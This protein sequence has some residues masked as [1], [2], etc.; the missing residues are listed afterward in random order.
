MFWKC[1]SHESEGPTRR[2]SW[3]SL[4]SLPSW[5]PLAHFFSF[6]SDDEQKGRPTAGPVRS[7]TAGETPD[8]LFRRSKRSFR[9]APY[10]TTDRP[11][12]S[13]RCN[14]KKTS[15][16]VLRPVRYDEPFPRRRSNLQ[17]TMSPIESEECRLNADESGKKRI[18]RT[19]RSKS[20]H[21]LPA[22]SPPKSV[23]FRRPLI[24]LQ[25]VAVITLEDE[26]EELK[27]NH[28]CAL[29]VQLLGV[30][31]SKDFVPRPEDED[32]KPRIDRDYFRGP[33]NKR[34]V[35]VDG[36]ESSD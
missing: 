27:K 12:H 28:L 4:F 14:E 17:A 30:N 19:P 10:S 25:T 33:F 2:W 20:K 15:C 8:P 26:K 35:V 3:A 31:R 29:E 21:R 9:Y 34:L 22:R 11:L 18:R 32:V 16:V 6:G 23:L 13:S 24:A 1:V 36:D 5:N 7:R